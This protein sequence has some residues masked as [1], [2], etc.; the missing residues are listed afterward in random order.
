VTTSKTRALKRAPKRT[1]LT[2]EQAAA[3]LEQREQFALESLRELGAR[4]ALYEPR[5]HVEADPLR[6]TREHI[7]PGACVAIFEST[8]GKRKTVST[9]TA[10]LALDEARSWIHYNQTRLAPDLRFEIAPNGSA[11][12]VRHQIVGDT[13]T[14]ER[15]R[16]ET[17]RRTLSLEGTPHLVDAHGDPINGEINR[18]SQFNS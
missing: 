6:D 7:T 14:T 12:L 5:T 1:V 11:Y 2:E 3:I 10:V 16:R 15:R 9:T 13:A 17:E 18:A 4:I 8:M